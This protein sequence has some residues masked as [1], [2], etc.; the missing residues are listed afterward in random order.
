MLKPYHDRFNDLVFVYVHTGRLEDESNRVY[1]ISSTIV[2]LG[3]SPLE[4]ESLVR[5]NE[6][7]ERE[8]YYSNLSKKELESAPTSQEVGNRIKTFLLGQRFAFAFNDNSNIDELKKFV[9]IDRI[10]DLSF[11]SEFFLQ[12]LESHSLK[13]L[14]EYLFRKR[15]DQ[16]SFSASEIVLLSVE[17]VKHIC[18]TEL[19]DQKYSRSG[20]LRYYLKKSDTLFG[21]AFFN[22]TRSYRNYF[23]GLFDPC[24][25]PDTENWKVFLEKVDSSTP[26]DKKDE[27]H[28][29]I[30]EQEIKERF[31]KMASSGKGFKY[32]S[33]Q[34]EY[35]HHITRALN[36][37]AI[38]CVEAGTGTGK[39]QGYLVPVMEFLRRNTGV[40][41]AVS[42]Y[43]KSLQDQIFQ[44]EIGFTKEIFKI[45]EDIP[46]A[47]LKGK[48]SYVCVEKLDYSYEK[49]LSGDKLLAWLY[50]LNNVYNYRST[51]TDVI[52]ENV[53]KYLNGQNF[54][55]HTLNTASA[56]EGCDSRHFRCPA[57]VV[58]AKARDS[59]LIVTN[60]HKLALL[61]REPIL[62][63][64]FRNYVI[65][66]ANHFEEAVRSAFRAEANSKEIHQSVLY[67]EKSIR[68]IHSKAVGV[69]ESALKNSLVGITDLTTNI[70][71]LRS[72]LTSI[73]P[74]VKF[75]EESVLIPGHANFREG[76]INT[77]L[78]AMRDAILS[79]YNG[80]KAVME[81][82]YRVSLKIV[83]R[84]AKKV[85]SEMNL[86]NSFSESLKQIE[87]SLVSQNSVPSY[88]LLR[89]NFV[90]FA[91]PVEVDE[92][93]RKNIYE[94]KDSIVY[95]AA[96]L[97]QKRSFDCFHE[98]TGLTE[99]LATEGESD[100]EKSV[101][102][103]AIPSSFSSSLME[104][105]VPEDA[106][107][108][109]YE[110]KNEWLSR[111]VP[112][113]SD[114]VK[115]NKGRSLVLFSSYEDLKHVAEKISEEVTNSGYPL[116]IQKP[117]LPT[118]NLCDEF[119][120]V[121]ESVL[122]GV[123]TF[124]HGVDFRGDTLTQVIVTRIPFP[125]PKDPIQMMRKNIFLAKKYWE[126]FYYQTDIK[127]K[128]GI[129]RLIRSETD[130][131]TVV[132]LDSRFRAKD[133]SDGERFN[134]KRGKESTDEV[135]LK[136]YKTSEATSK[137]QYIMEQQHFFS[138]D[139]IKRHPDE[140]EEWSDL[141]E[142]EVENLL[143]QL[144]QER[145]LSEHKVVNILNTLASI[146]SEKSVPILLKYLK[147]SNAK[148]VKRAAKALGRIGS[149]EVVR[150]L[151]EILTDPSSII[152]RRAIML[153]GELRAKEIKS[154][155]QNISENDESEF[156]RLA[157]HDALKLINEIDS[158]KEEHFNYIKESDE[159]DHDFFIRK[160]ENPD[161]SF[162][163]LTKTNDKIT[164]PRI[165]E[166]RKKHRRAYEPWSD[167][168]DDLLRQQFQSTNNIKH[169]AETFQRNPGAIRTR[170][171]KLDLIDEV[172]R[173]QKTKEPDH[174]HRPTEDKPKS[175]IDSE[176]RRSK[177]ATAEQK[178][179]IIK[180]LNESDLTSD[181]IAE[182][183][184]ISPPTVWAFKAHVTMGTYGKLPGKRLEP[185]QKQFVCLAVSRKYSGYCVAGKEITGDSETA[186]VRPV[187]K[188][189]NGELSPSDLK[190]RDGDYPKL[191][192]VLTLSIK[193]P[194]PHYYQTENYLIDESRRWSKNG[195]AQPP[196]LSKL[197]DDV[198][199]LWV[200]G[201]HS[202]GGHNDRI[203]LEL[204][205]E[206]LTT[207]LLLINPN[208]F[209]I[210][211]KK[212]PGAKK[213][214][215]AE[216]VHNGTN[217][218]LIV[219]D[220]SVEKKYG[221]KEEGEYRFDK[222]D[223]YLCISIGEP[224]GGYCYKL[225][226]GVIGI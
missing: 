124:W 20:T 188:R 189:K 181:Q 133:Y 140:K 68:K 128:Q 208:E 170:I 199:I 7:T 115:N 63:G 172:E 213:R 57:Q 223:I 200:N 216:F 186:W 93:I 218:S 31:Q 65:D 221:G 118:I 110:N 147:S 78:Q 29:K 30:S 192:D 32:R 184:G 35:A 81:D 151:E 21:E 158:P 125:S 197:C 154:K 224:F 150:K 1:S 77:H 69:E 62:S 222:G 183:V 6:F 220:P 15:R 54:L 8:R 137:P 88:I 40:R 80:V 204:A 38:L 205:N 91:S 190:L 210:V 66:E 139:K 37:S 113:I 187:S 50:L 219:T 130:K 99:P 4:F 180:L 111:V 75:M 131:G 226:A 166:I 164:D 212:E 159:H 162:W 136:K 209:K 121:K 144:Q 12:Q 177:K 105:M 107:S 160:V 96:T 163:S 100:S 138:D 24:S 22:I 112:M 95:T 83:S 90:L 109:R 132:I 28:R 13:R 145:D 41:V 19:N 117:G 168:E 108:G 178:A 82:D 17:V 97:C 193:K 60:H 201:D 196:D 161:I 152:R 87:D 53:W 84:T 191:L 33:S 51:D 153:L 72:T 5:Y 56:K 26:S 175:E 148:F 165:L 3:K 23:G 46:V 101:E 167:Q 182:N 70:N 206:E 49:A 135:E 85:Q 86:L 25:K 142:A 146:A 119:R 122:F 64:L 120:T 214:I 42:T 202:H 98:I 156:V 14:W 207:S 59:R 71:E 129:G 169:L 34:V 176:P 123:D 173:V 39:T 43:T 9:G 149:R 143:Y 94:D 27:T 44:R 52:G 47:L 157:A 73:N 171:K 114:L 45:Y 174:A 104:I 48:S 198:D 79:I 18:G 58:T 203:P 141:G 2:R 11:A 61:D 76:H 55:A 179:E 194:F 126:R 103:V 36:E 225:V 89:K 102:S 217:Y 127:L 211:V 134:L 185:N 155:L 92:I 195:T 74:R 116:L 106:V 16:V 67:L 10:I 215:R